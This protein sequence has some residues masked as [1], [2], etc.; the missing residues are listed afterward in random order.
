M[1]YAIM[2]TP[3]NKEIELRTIES[4]DGNAEDS[5]FSMLLPITNIDQFSVYSLPMLNSQGGQ[6]GQKFFLCTHNDIIEIEGVAV[7]PIPDKSVAQEL[8]NKL[9]NMIEWQR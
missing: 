2:I 7:I 1:K 3:D 9:R 6:S 5:F 8:I 4:T